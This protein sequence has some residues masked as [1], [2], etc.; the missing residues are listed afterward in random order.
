MS[1][2]KPRTSRVLGSKVMPK[3]AGKSRVSGSKMALQIAR[4]PWSCK[5]GAARSFAA[6]MLK[7]L[8]FFGIALFQGEVFNRQPPCARGVR[9]AMRGVVRGG[10]TLKGVVAL[11]WRNEMPMNVAFHLGCGVPHIRQG[12]LPIGP[13]GALAK[14]FRTFRRIPRH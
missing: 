6:G 2:P 12:A 14:Y 7:V 10:G 8:M 3:I 13:E 9:G 5:R 11:L 1:G 4:K